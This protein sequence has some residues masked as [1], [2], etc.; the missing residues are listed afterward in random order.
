[1]NILWKCIISV[2]F[3]CESPKNWRNCAFPQIFYTRNFG[4]I[5]VFYAV[6]I[7]RY[8]IIIQNKYTTCAE[9][10]AT[11]YLFQI[12]EDKYTTGQKFIGRVFAYFE[13]HA[14]VWLLHWTPQT[15]LSTEISQ[16]EGELQMFQKNQAPLFVLTFNIVCS[17]N[18]TCDV[19]N[20][21]DIIQRNDYDVVSFLLFLCSFF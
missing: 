7:R 15:F 2:G 8:T 17:N 12:Y 9:Y 5:S 10:W 1:M 19:S 16:R 13:F 14:L 18:G 4:E 21:L 11:R 6:P 3:L 20:G